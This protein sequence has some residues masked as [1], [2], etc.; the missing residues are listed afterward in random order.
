MGLPSLMAVMIFSAKGDINWF[1]AVPLSVG[2]ILGSLIGTRVSLGPNASKWIFW[3]LVL[4]LGVQVVQL[5][6]RYL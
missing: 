5:T 6:F 2:G 4:V 1:W 3:V